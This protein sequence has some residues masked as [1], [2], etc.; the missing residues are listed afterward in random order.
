[1]EDTYI[2]INNF[3][4][5]FVEAELIKILK[6]KTGGEGLNDGIKLDFS[7]LLDLMLLTFCGLCF[8]FSLTHIFN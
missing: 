2:I 1:M 7:N 5:T 8:I 3:C 4:K 6:L